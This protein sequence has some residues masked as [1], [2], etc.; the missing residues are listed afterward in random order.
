MPHEIEHHIFWKLTSRFSRKSEMRMFLK[1]MFPGTP[2]STMKAMVFF[3]FFYFLGRHE[4]NPLRLANT[5]APN[6]PPDPGRSNPGSISL[7]VPDTF[8][9]HHL[10]HERN[11]CLAVAPG[12]LQ[13]AGVRTGKNPMLIA[14]NGKIGRGS[15]RDGI[16]AGTVA[17]PF[18]IVSP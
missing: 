13:S 17:R 15:C 2:L 6:A 18:S 7:Q 3:A 9:C 11:Q 10:F 12:E 14:I 1:S 8:T 5:A 16:H 4:D